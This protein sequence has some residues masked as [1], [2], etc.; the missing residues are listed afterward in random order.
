VQ[1]CAICSKDNYR[2]VTSKED[3]GALPGVTVAVKGTT[4]GSVTDVSGTYKISVPASATTLVFTFVGMKT[5]EVEIGTQTTI[6]VVLESSA[7]NLEGVVVT[8]LGITREKKSLGYSTQEVKGDLVQSV[9]T[10]NFINTL[11]G[12]VS[13]VQIKKNTNIGGSTNIVMRGSKSITGNNQALFVIDGVPVNNDITNTTSQKQAGLGYD[14]GN[15]ASDINPEDIESI[16]VLKGAAAT[17][18]YGSRAANG[19]VMITTKKG[20]AGKG[21]KKGIGITLNSGVTMGF[22]DKSTFPTYQKDYG[23]GYGKYYSSADGYF[24][25]IT[26]NGVDELW[27]PTTEDASFVINLIQT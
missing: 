1:F 22:V 6:N 11:S 2:K 4:T 23:A 12:K 16:N 5:Q 21:G 14:Y 25:D 3:G 8:A 9:K 10:D 15:T 18:L 17:A 20:A 26:F 27:A 19:V 24:N 7:T 13:G